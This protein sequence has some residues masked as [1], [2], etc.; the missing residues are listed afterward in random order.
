PQEA[1]AREPAAAWSCRRTIFRRFKCE[2]TRQGRYWSARFP[3][4]FEA[5]GALQVRSFLLDGRRWPATAMGCRCSTDRATRRHMSEL[6]RTQMGKAKTHRCF[7]T[8][9]IS[10][11]ITSRGTNHSEGSRGNSRVA[12]TTDSL[13]GGA[14]IAPASPS[15]ERGE[16]S[17]SQ[18]WRQ[19]LASSLLTPSCWARARRSVRPA[20][21]LTLRT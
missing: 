6:D 5:A 9:K 10:S 12:P 17:P 16:R 15:P 3:L 8:P 14:P 7:S 2:Q 13:A 1:A 19:Q 21:A 4:I 18:E 11:S 20:A